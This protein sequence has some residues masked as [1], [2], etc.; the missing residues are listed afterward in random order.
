MAASECSEAAI[1]VWLLLLQ[2]FDLSEVLWDR[3][4]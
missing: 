4:C 1:Y 3:V 2:T